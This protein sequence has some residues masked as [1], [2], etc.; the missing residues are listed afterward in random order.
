MIHDA[1]S[2]YVLCVDLC[3]TVEDRYLGAVHLNEAVVDAEGKQ[4]GEGVFNGG[5]TRITHSED[6]ATCGFDDIFGNGL[7]DGLL[8]QIETLYLVTVILGGRIEGHHEV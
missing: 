4:G 3:R 8:R 1:Y 7:D 6:G 5:A 2:A